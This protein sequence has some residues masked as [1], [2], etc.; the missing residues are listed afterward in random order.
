MNRRKFITIAG[1]TILVAGGVFYLFSDKNNFT[2]SDINAKPSG[3]I[4]LRPDAR[5]ILYLASLAPCG[6]NTQPWLVN[7]IAPYHWI[8]GNDKSK[9]LP[10]TDP[11][12]ISFISAIFFSSGLAAIIFHR[13]AYPK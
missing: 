10:G 3:K 9:W 1:G 12:F 7:Y 5:E 6:H 2:R 4:S 11:V 13:Q 8:I